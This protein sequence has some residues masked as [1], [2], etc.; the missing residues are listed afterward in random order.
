MPT[1]RD[2]ADPLRRDDDAP[3]TV[4]RVS[5]VEERTLLEVAATGA[6]RPP[7]RP[8][9]RATGASRITADAGR[10]R[11]RTRCPIDDILRGDHAG[12]RR[13]CCGCCCSCPDQQLRVVDELGPGPAAEHGRPRAVPGDRARSA[14]R[15]TRAIHPPFDRGRAPRWRS[16]TRPARSPA[17]CT[18]SPGP[19]RAA[20]GRR[21]STTR[22]TR[23]PAR[24]RGRPAATSAATTTEAAA[25]RGRART[26]TRDA[27]AR[28][29]LDHDRQINEA[30]RSLDR[31]RDQTRPAHPTRPLA[32]H[33]P[34]EV[35]HV[36]RSP[37]QATRRGRPVAAPP[38]QGG[39]RGGQAR[40]PAP[41][42]RR[43]PASPSPATT[44]TMTTTT[45]STSGPEALAEDGA[46]VGG[47]GRRRGRRRR[48]G[49]QAAGRRP[50]QARP[51]G[52]RGALR[53]GARGALR[54]HDRDR[55][56]GPD[57]PQG[58]RQ[59]R[60]ADRR[61]GGRPGQGHRARRADGRGALE[62]RSSR[63][64]SGPSTTPS[65]RPAPRSRSTACRSARRRTTWSRDAI[66][67]RDGAADLLVADARLPPRQ[68]R[69]G[70]PV[71]RD[72][73][74]PQ[75]GQAARRTP[76][77]RRPTPATFQRAP[78][79]GVPRRPQRRPRLARQ[80]RAAGDLR[81]DPR[82]R[83]L[84]GAR[85]LDPGRQR[86]RPAQADGL[87]PRG[88]AQHQAARPQGRRSSASAATPASS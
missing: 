5:G 77:T 25:G 36:R 86:R 43:R 62:G 38:R 8:A 9:G 84:P 70:R 12:R 39:P 1:I 58:D 30:R 48:S 67:R 10:S 40:R 52:G 16:T 32:D 47:R 45:T 83:R 2:V 21:G 15:T 20:L 27:I 18:P 3:A 82:R 71:R 85:A 37:R 53:R 73:G 11:R 56:P 7:R 35:T 4:R 49:R 24:P 26:A 41:V 59:G 69:H 87:R 79:L 46:D 6:R 72:E 29:L 31:R 65:A 54:R 74:A 76:T 13:S 66:S 42:A 64:T 57:V 88:P 33:A 68:G 63:S 80:R 44:T 19:T 14:R 60:P 22:S 75:G 51:E 17:R 50:G 28:L 55:R 61:G 81:L 34:P 78:R 23:L